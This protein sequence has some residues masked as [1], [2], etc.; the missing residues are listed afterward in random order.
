MILLKLELTRHELRTLLQ[1]TT[2]SL[3]RIDRPISDLHAREFLFLLLAGTRPHLAEILS[4]LGQHH[5][6]LRVAQRSIVLSFVPRRFRSQ[7]LLIPQQSLLCLLLSGASQRLLRGNDVRR[8][9]IP[10]GVLRRA[11]HSLDLRGTLA[12]DATG[13]LGQALSCRAVDGGVHDR[14][15]TKLATS[16]LVAGIVSA[17]LLL[18]LVFVMVVEKG[19]VDLVR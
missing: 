2:L 10:F 12:V 5:V 16:I 11:W 18:V 15:L 8:D 6:L 13:P 3:R 17:A 1:L 9:R 7:L 4:R 14:R 19:A